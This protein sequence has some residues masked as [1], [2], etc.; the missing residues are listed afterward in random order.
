MSFLVAGNFP[1]PRLWA[2]KN[3]WIS[4]RRRINWM[5]AN[6]GLLNVL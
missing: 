2:M 1:V 3:A 6:V 4:I 5:P